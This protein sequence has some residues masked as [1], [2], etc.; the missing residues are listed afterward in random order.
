MVLLPNIVPFNGSLFS[1]LSIVFT[2]SFFYYCLYYE[3]VFTIGSLEHRGL[4]WS[5]QTIQALKN[6]RR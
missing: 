1:C 4:G 6:L 3:T 5:L 2:K